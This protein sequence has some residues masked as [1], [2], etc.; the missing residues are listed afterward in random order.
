MHRI[1]VVMLGIAA[2]GLA[3]CQK[4]APTTE[5]SA[6]GRDEPAAAASADLPDTSAPNESGAAEASQGIT[7]RYTCDQGHSVAI[8]R[9]DT[10]RVT[11]ADGRVVEIGRVADSSPPRY[12]G[13]ALSFEVGSD[14]A[15]LGQDEVGGF[16]CR[17][18]D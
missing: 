12:R 7:M 5:T 17:E 13:E 10:A 6:P 1:A 16:A 15:T 18:A 8:V 3:A 4:P 2:A 14:G 9:G 11:L